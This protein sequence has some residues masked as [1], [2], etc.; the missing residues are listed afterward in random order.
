MRRVWAGEAD[1]CQHPSDNRSVLEYGLE[2]GK[3]YEPSECIPVK[4]ALDMTDNPDETIFNL[5]LIL[6]PS[7]RFISEQGEGA[8]AL[9][10]NLSATPGVQRSIVFRDCKVRS[11]ETDL[12]DKTFDLYRDK[13]LRLW[14]TEQSPDDKF[15]GSIGTDGRLAR[16]NPLP[17]V[18]QQFWDIADAG[19]TGR[20]VQVLARRES[21]N[22]LMD[23]SVHWLRLP[24]PPRRHPVVIMIEK[25]WEEFGKIVS[26]T[27]KWIEKRWE[28]FGKIVSPTIKWI[29][30]RFSRSA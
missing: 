18:F 2:Y 12:R 28:E 10:A 25:R 5:D 1:P 7:E 9:H 20:V 27:I 30:E 11:R 26:P 14:V 4:T 17:V 23:L 22:E 16:L 13:T 3:R 15:L 24:V 19:E 21:L 29:A 6:G 8:H